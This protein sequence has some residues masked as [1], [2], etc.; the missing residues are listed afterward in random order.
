VLKPF[1]SERFRT[2]LSR[3]RD[4]ISRSAPDAGLATLAA[5]LRS[6]PDYLTRLPVRT[7][8]RTVFVEMGAVDWLEAADNTSA[9]T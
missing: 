8:G 1:T 9:S 5:T 7:G 4:R 3:A 6:R 2:A